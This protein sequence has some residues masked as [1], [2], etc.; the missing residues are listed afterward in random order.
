MKHFFLLILT[1]T[2]FS[3]GVHAQELKR[4]EPDFSDY[5]PL[6]NAAGYEV[7][8]F[9]ISSL[10]DETYNIEFI[11]QEY[12]KGV[13]VENQS[14]EAS[15]RYIFRNRR[16]LSD[17]PEEYHQ[18]IIAEGPIYDLEKGICTLGEK[19]SIGFSPS[20]DSLKSV[21]M[22]VD[23]IGAIRK[24]LPMKAQ[25]TAPGKYEYMYDYRPFKV[26]EIQLGAYIPLVM[27][28]SYWYDE[29]Y[30]LFRFCGESELD[31]DLSSKMLASIPHY[32]VLGMT[33]TKK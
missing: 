4:T 28:G 15:L 2:I 10:K 29:Q 8:T 5:I 3:L 12:S 1:G 13:L 9:D 11:F 32:Y 27:F 16:M 25:N 6:L 18:E 23:N 22:T 17:F 26:S 14:E 30:D 21:S 19:I 24:L 31:P 7:F 20:A 33:V